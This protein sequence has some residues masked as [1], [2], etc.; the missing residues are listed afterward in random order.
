MLGRADVLRHE[1]EVRGADA[2]RIEAHELSGEAQDVGGR[3]CGREVVVG[4]PAL[5]RLLTCLAGDDERL[6]I[7]LAERRHRELK[8]VSMRSGVPLMRMVTS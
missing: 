3:G 8:E 5:R 6:E 1:I 2:N 4:L 7:S